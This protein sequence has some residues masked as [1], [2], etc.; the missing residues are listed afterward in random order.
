MDAKKGRPPIEPA[1]QT[2]GERIE[3]L[4]SFGL[5]DEEIAAGLGIDIDT[6][7]SEF[8]EHL[9]A[10]PARARCAVL[11]MIH[12]K[13]MAGSIQAARL[14][15]KATGV[16]AVMNKAPRKAPWSI[17]RE[18]EAQKARDLLDD[19][20]FADWHFLKGDKA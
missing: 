6:L 18:R 1:P 11:S 3:A 13:A 4:A 15:L 8:M 9:V 14:Y 19:P 2:E 16:E 12:A 20:E 7:R 17:R 5:D 10:G